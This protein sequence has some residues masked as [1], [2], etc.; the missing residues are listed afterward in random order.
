[1]SSN[2]IQVTSSLSNQ[3]HSFTTTARV[4]R[5]A[6]NAV[7]VD[8]ELVSPEHLE[9]RRSGKSWEVVD[10]GSEHGSFVG[11]ERVSRT[12]VKGALTVR[13]GLNGPD[14]TLTIPR[15]S[16]KGWTPLAFATD[17]AGRYFSD[18][19]PENMS[20]RTAMIRAAFRIHHADT[21]RSWL[22]RLRS[23][24]AALTLAVLVAAVAGIVAIIQGRRVRALRATAGTIF[25][26]MKALELD[27]RRLEA[28]TGPDSTFAE[29]HARLEAQYDELIKTLGIYSD[30]TPAEVR[31]IYRTIHR[32]GESEAT[33][34]SGFMAEIR[35][36]IKQ[37][38]SV[39]LETAFARAVA[40][41][42]GPLVTDTFRVHHLPREFFYIALQESKFDPK[43]IG[44]SGNFGVPKGLWQL[45]PSTAEAYGLR[46]GPLRG[47]RAFDPQDERHDPARSTAAAARYLE[48][49]Y[50]TDAQASG[51]LV[52]ASYN[53]G[54]TR[55]R[56][57]LRSLPES[58]VERNYWSLLDRHRAE[59]PGETQAYVLRIIAAA[60]IGEDPQLFGFSV[61]GPLPRGGSR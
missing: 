22:R 58:P 55:M 57:L 51:L 36:T 1:M 32:L 61:T 18:K 31:V 48:D 26:T 5:A 10:L 27:I 56:R 49:L 41:G 50:S 54:D 13:L 14:L 24:R 43:A 12:P 15:H 25:T 2:E 45:I 4:G 30:R 52:L 19:D 16:S 47:D 46:L 44:P 6:S 29:R 17:I 21:T 3:L 35:R 34:P 42:L 60:A 59:I 9:I 11:G 33:L 8:H 53:M 7:V 20:S 38:R 40:S 23:L 28:A 37:W 39:D